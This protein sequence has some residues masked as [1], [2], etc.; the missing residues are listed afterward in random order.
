[1]RTKAVMRQVAEIGLVKKTEKLPWDL[2]SDSLRAFYSIGPSTKAR[3]IG[4]G[5][6]EIFRM[7]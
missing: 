6:S 5:G 7:R 1:M 4:A 3:T 2:M